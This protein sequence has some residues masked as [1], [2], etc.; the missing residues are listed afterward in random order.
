MKQNFIIRNRAIIYI[1]EFR[2][3]DRSFN[4]TQLFDRLH[5]RNKQINKQTRLQ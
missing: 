5:E 4:P 1:D 3:F 2:Y